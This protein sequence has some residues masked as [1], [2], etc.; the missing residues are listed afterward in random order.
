MK[1]SVGVT[2]EKSSE[3]ELSVVIPM[4]KEE[5][6]GNPR[7]LQQSKQLK[8]QETKKRTPSNVQ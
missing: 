6:C 7:V 4:L 5:R 8:R 1:Y 2:K 3:N